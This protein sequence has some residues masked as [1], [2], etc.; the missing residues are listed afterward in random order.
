MSKTYV[1]RVLHIDCFGDAIIQLPTELIEELEW[2]VGDTLDF[3]IVDS[4]VIIK[5]LS[6]EKRNVI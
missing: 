2:K 4:S 3:E 1:T 5:N 6:K